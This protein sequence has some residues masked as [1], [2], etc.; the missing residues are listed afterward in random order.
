MVDPCSEGSEEKPSNRE[1]PDQKGKVL[2]CLVSES[3][4][5]DGGRDQVSGWVMI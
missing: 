4:D 1:T 2:D 3:R 5:A